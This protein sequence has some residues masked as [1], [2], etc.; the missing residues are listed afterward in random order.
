MNKYYFITFLVCANSIFAQSKEELKKENDK[1]KSEIVSKDDK[2]KILTKEISILQDKNKEPNT[3]NTTD[4]KTQKIIADN[5]RVFFNE[6]F[7]SKYKNNAKY[8][9][10]TGL[11]KFADVYKFENYNVVLANIIYDETKTKD[12][13]ELAKLAFDFNEKYIV[14]SNLHELNKDFISEKYVDEDAKKYKESLNLL[15]VNGFDALALDRDNLVNKI[16]E[17]KRKSCELKLK[18]DRLKAIDIVDNAAIAS[19][20]AAMKKEYPFPYLQ[21]VITEMSSNTKN[22][23]DDKLPECKKDAEKVPTDIETKIT[24]EAT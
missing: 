5:N 22:Y 7:E 6:I 20:Y 15:K 2:L 8:F 24:K 18:L 3:K 10:I 4:K 19:K 16:D 12:E 9:S 23:T 17:Y 1:L 13:H 11:E 14:F 21:K